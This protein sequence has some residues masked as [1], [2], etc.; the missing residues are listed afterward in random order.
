MFYGKTKT[1]NLKG[2]KNIMTSFCIKSNNVKV[3]DYILSDLYNINFDNII[4][5]K[6][7]FSKYTNIILH[8]NGSDISGFYNVL[9]NIL[10]KCIIDVYEPIIIRNI[11]LL[12]YFYFDISDI[13]K[14]ERNCYELLGIAYPNSCHFNIYK[15]DNNFD[16]RKLVLENIISRYIKSNKSIVLDGFVKF[17]IKS[18]IKY[19]EDSV[20]NSV[21][22]FVV[23]KEYNDF[24]KLIKLYIESK[25]ASSDTIY[26]VYNNGE[27]TLLD[28]NKEIIH[29]D[30]TILDS[31]Y[32]SDIS[33]SS[34][35]YTLNSLLFLLPQRL[36]INLYSPEDEFIT[37]LKLIFS[38]R[39]IIK[40]AE[41]SDGVSNVKKELK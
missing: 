14:I 10:C 33:F 5:S 37:T 39:V 1:P 40:E 11:I 15:S 2:I 16:D 27:S 25:P 24:I 29:C 30:K 23:D 38:D 3:I 34:N 7:E 4:F 20:D 32:L 28:E 6:R 35:D 22:Q 26:L 36:I 18:Y 31:S 9:S 13:K 8:Y 12:E 17:R 21:N 19:I 41:I